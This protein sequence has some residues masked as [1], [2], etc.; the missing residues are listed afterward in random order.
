MI[1]GCQRKMIMIRGD[2]ESTFETAYFVMRPE[3]QGTAISCDGDMVEEAMRLID[4]IFP[5]NEGNERDVNKK[6][7]S[8]KVRR[9][10]LFLVAFASGV[11]LTSLILAVLNAI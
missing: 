5:K 10:V 7:D 8:E 4:G 2:S 3:K 6:V 1:K 9:V 11:G